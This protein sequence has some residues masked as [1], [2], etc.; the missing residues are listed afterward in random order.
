V[1]HWHLHEETLR[2][3]TMRLISYRHHLPLSRFLSSGAWGYAIYLIAIRRTGKS[4][5]AV[6]FLRPTGLHRNEKIYF[7]S[8]VGWQQRELYSF[9]DIFSP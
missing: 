1:T 2:E 8:S 3:A 6:L 7:Q 9:I 4:T 5:S